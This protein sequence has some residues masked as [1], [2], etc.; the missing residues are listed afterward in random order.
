VRRLHALA[1]E[2]NLSFGRF[3][4][5]IN[6]IRKEECTPAASQLKS[7]IGADYVVQLPENQEIA[8]MSEA[9]KSL[10]SIPSTNAVVERLDAFLDLWNSQACSLRS[11]APRFGLKN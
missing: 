7:E 3:S 6:R 8:E 2:M 5:I 9:G 10:W 4:I 1:R 11:A